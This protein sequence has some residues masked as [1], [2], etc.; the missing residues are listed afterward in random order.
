MASPPV[1]DVILEGVALLRDQ[2][3]PL[4]ANLLEG[5]RFSAQ[6][7]LQTSRMRRQA[8]GQDLGMKRRGV[9]AELA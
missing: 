1:G 7:R 6:P 8:T 4:A 3:F 5:L 2:L 9:G